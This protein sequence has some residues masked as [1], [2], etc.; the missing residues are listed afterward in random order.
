MRLDDDAFERNIVA[1]VREHGC[2]I[3]Y[4]FDPEGV[5]PDFAYS[6]GFPET[7]GQPEVIVFGLSREVMHFMINEILRQCRDGLQLEDGLAIS[8]LLEG[9]ECI[10]CAIPPRDIVR[11]HFNSALWFRQ[12]TTGEQAIDACQIVWPSAVDGLF[13]WEDGCDD[14]VRNFQ[15]CLFAEEAQS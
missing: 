9:H 14:S 3:N 15:P 7:V 1:N 2:H 8:G 12:F 11:E 5:E 13:P 4:V 10:A 6:V